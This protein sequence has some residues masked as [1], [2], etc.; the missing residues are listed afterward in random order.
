MKPKELLFAH[1]YSEAV[2]AHHNHLLEHPELNYYPGLGHALL[3]LGRF[4]EAM[5]AFT[6]ANDVTGHFKTSQ[7]GSNQNR[8][9]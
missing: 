3:G 6:K 7:P 9:L 1:R 4:S 8:P 5:E 2:A